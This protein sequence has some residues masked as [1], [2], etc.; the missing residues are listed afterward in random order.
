[1]KV[2]S[3]NH[4]ST[5]SKFSSI[6][7]VNSTGNL[8]DNNDNNSQ[9][10]SLS[11]F[12]IQDSVD[13]VPRSSYDSDSFSILYEGE[14]DSD[15]IMIDCS[16]SEEPQNIHNNNNN[17]EY[18][19]NKKKLQFPIEVTA[20]VAD[21]RLKKRR[22]FSFFC[23]DE[24][25][26]AHSL[27]FDFFTLDFK[28]YITELRFRRFS[29]MQ[30]SWK[31]SLFLVTLPISAQSTMC[32]VRLIDVYVSKI[33]V[34]QFLFASLITAYC[35][36]W[37]ISCACIRVLMKFESKFSISERVDLES[38]SLISSARIGH[39]WVGGSSSRQNPL[40]NELYD[41][42]LS[43]YHKDKLAKI[44]QLDKDT[45]KILWTCCIFGV[46][47]S[48]AV[49]ATGFADMVFLTGHVFC[50]FEKVPGLPFIIVL[51]FPLQLALTTSIS[52]R[53][54]VLCELLSKCSAVFIFAYLSFYFPD[55]RPSYISSIYGA[56]MTAFLWILQ[57]NIRRRQL[58]LFVFCELLAHKCVDEDRQFNA[59]N[60]MWLI[61]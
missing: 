13:G 35:V 45:N 60:Q 48:L 59:R 3:R 15:E 11:S 24:N 36:I 27:S 1:M 61:S 37:I 23:N 26:K 43:H 54:L 19:V 46:T 28:D 22:H 55:F 42:E 50:F 8:V 32:L 12:K 38:V 53:S 58:L 47:I 21:T 9:I 4:F 10:S 17:N 31:N 44:H 51:L 14:E 6:V 25:I 18:L 40:E 57:W 39:R 30:N 34:S 56:L 41:E 29:I 5:S 49:I 33:Q 20:P 2:D 7:D 16:N 52:W